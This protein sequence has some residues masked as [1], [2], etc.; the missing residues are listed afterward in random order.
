MKFIKVKLWGKE[1]GS[2]GWDKRK[3]LSYFIYNPDGIEDMP[4]I[5]P[6]LAPKAFRKALKPI[7]G[8]SRPIYH[9]LPPFLA[10]SLPDYW[11]SLLFEKWIEEK[12]ISRNMLTPLDRLVFMGKRGMGAFEYEPA[13][14]E[15]N[16]TQSIDIKSLFDLSVKIFED[17]YK[18]SIPGGE[19]LTLHALLQVGTSAGGRQKKAILAINS[20]TGE[21]RSGQI[22]GLEGY[23]YCILKFGDAAIPISEIEMTYYE[24]ATVAGI[25]MEESRI[26]SIDGIRH[27]LTKRFDRKG[28]K[29]ILMQ[30]LAAINPD[31]LSY[32]DLFA[33]CRSLNLT[34]AEMQQLYR[35]MV[36][37][38]LANNTDDH[39][40]NF[41]FLLEEGGRWTLSPA[42]DITFILNSTWTGPNLE[43]V[44][45]IGG[46]RTD[47]TKEDLLDFAV[48]QGVRNPEA[49]IEE[50]VKGVSMFSELAKKNEI[51]QPFLGM[52]NR[53]IQEKLQDFGYVEVPPQQESLVDDRGRQI[54]GFRIS[55]NSKGIYVVE[56]HIDGVRKR[57]FIRPGS[58]EYEILHNKDIYSLDA[59]TITTLALSLF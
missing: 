55:I 5:A 58:K 11:G 34:A 31:A 53:R 42:Y 45:S 36:F 32:E 33:T 24:M 18:A 30:T 46:K 59:N 48:Y 13:A 37:N 20:V 19:D 2:L 47:I 7:Y 1:I 51:P 27:F 9:R 16:K 6:L 38:V 54:E 49:I 44:F 29:K 28:N 40:K 41:S 14:E 21:I 4:D 25:K 8:D 52:I 39:I 15:L 50:V 57:R 12:K 22:D 23:D 56:A 10:D 43:H 35:R 26:L 3:N 17:R